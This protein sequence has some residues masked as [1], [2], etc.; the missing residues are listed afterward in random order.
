MLATAGVYLGGGIAP[1]ILPALRGRT[2]LDAFA[3]KGRLRSLLEAVPVR[4]VLN[5][6]AALVGAARRAALEGGLL[7]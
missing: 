1:R 7:A 2:F 3:A 5:D 4:V 6:Q